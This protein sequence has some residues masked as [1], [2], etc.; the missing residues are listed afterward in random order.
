MYPAADNSDNLYRVILMCKE[1]VGTKE[2]FVRH[3][4]CT[5]LKRFCASK[6]FGVNG[7]GVD[8]TFDCG[9]FDL[10]ITTYPHPLLVAKLTGV[11]PT[12]IGPMFVHRRK[13]LQTYLAFFSSCGRLQ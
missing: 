9:D 6:E 2:E 8:P 7:L 1:S 11:H 3:V 13:T 12:M 5:D 10:T 4:S